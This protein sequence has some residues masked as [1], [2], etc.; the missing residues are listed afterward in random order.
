MSAAK[1]QVG[2][3][4]ALIA[5]L[6]IVVAAGCARPHGGMA[7]ASHRGEAPSSMMHDVNAFAMFGA[8]NVNVVAV[9]CAAR[10]QLQQG[11]AIVKDGCFTGD[12]NVVLCTDVSA[13]NP[14]MCAPHKGELAV[15]GSSSD[16]VS[17]ARIR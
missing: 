14:V 13:P 6:A 8:S 9:P 10:V 17:Y 7:D 11:S 15:A 5:L 12:T 3:H 2:T 4:A 1:R 16:T